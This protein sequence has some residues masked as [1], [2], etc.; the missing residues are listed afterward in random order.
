MGPAGRSISLLEPDGVDSWRV[1]DGREHGE[2]V[3]RSPETRAGEIQKL[4]FATYPL[5]RHPST[6]G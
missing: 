2:L 4:T 6:F 3:L 5:T 1:V